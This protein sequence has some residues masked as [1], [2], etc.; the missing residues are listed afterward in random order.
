MSSPLPCN[1][2][3][4]DAAVIPVLLYPDVREAVA[5]LCRTFGF[6]ERLRI[7]THRIQLNSPGGSGALVVAEGAAPSGS[8][9]H[10]VMLRIGDA[11]GCFQAACALGAKPLRAPET[12]VY[13]ERQCTLADPFGHIWTLTET[14]R[15]VAPGSWGGEWVPRD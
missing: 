2:S 10:S 4:P 9:S 15:D 13:G 14:V 1:Q 5:W 12:H 11:D 3:M 7:G 8:P 6:T